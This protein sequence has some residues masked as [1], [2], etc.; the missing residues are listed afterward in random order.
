MVSPLK[1][2]AVWG[3]CVKFQGAYYVYVYI[4]IDEMDTKKKK[5]TITPSQKKKKTRDAY[6]YLYLL[7]LF[8]WTKNVNCLNQPINHWSSRVH[9]SPVIS[10]DALAVPKTK[11]KR[12]VREGTESTFSNLLLP[13]Q[14]KSKKWMHLIPNQ[15]ACFFNNN[16]N[17]NNNYNY[18]YNYNYNNNNNK[19]GDLEIWYFA[20]WNVAILDILSTSGAPPRP[21]LPSQ[22]A[23][24]TDDLIGFG[25]PKLNPSRLPQFT[26]RIL[27]FSKFMVPQK[28]CAQKIL[29]TRERQTL[30]R[31]VSLVL[32]RGGKG[33]Y[34]MCHSQRSG[35]Q[36][37]GRWVLFSL[38]NGH[39][40]LKC[41]CWSKGFIYVNLCIVAHIYIYMQNMYS[42]AIF[43]KPKRWESSQKRI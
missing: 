29:H 19:N 21:P 10:W 25:D 40:P 37:P 36:G 12:P 3:T 7:S 28:C 33:W 27:F 26:E 39:S 34:E 30:K 16:N 17:N 6:K 1:T 14:K 20:F 4:Y 2:M 18:N 35:I 9:G 31:W 5:Q 38:R 23:I 43:S 11:Q 32:K 22:Y 24:V 41:D 8:N 42:M 13:N 15:I